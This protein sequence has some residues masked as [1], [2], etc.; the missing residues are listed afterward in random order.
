[1]NDVAI[2]RAVRALPQEEQ[3][4]LYANVTKLSQTRKSLD[5]QEQHNSWLVSAKG[6]AFHFPTGIPSVKLLMCSFGYS[7]WLYRKY[8]L[9]GFVEVNGGDAVLDCGAFVGGF[10]YAAASIGCTVI[11]VEP[12][13]ENCEFIKTNLK[14]FE[15]VSIEC[16]G[17]YDHIG[18]MNINCVDNPVEHSLL[19]PD[20]GNL[21][22]TRTIPVLTTDSIT[23]NFGLA[24]IDFAKIEA[25]GVEWE[26]IKGMRQKLIPKLAIDCS[27]ERDGNSPMQDIKTLLIQKGYQTVTRGWILF[28]RKYEN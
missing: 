1:M 8:T 25:E 27:P 21:L 17:L 13:E 28:A 20:S 3:F 12:D 9:P 5:V 26:I 11:C 15:K 7:D 24:Q 18:E 6:E 4:K 23:D 16:A 10:A 14:A 19:K 2:R 22:E